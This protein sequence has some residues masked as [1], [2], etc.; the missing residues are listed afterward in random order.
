MTDQTRLVS[1]PMINIKD[2]SLICLIIYAIF[3]GFHV[4]NS[5]FVDHIL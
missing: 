4:E 5:F 2:I 1:L 3:A